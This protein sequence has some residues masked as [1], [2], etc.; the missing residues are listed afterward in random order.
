MYEAEVIYDGIKLIFCLTK[1]CM[2]SQN[3]HVNNKIGQKKNPFWNTD[4]WNN[5]CKVSQKDDLCIVFCC[6]IYR[7]ISYHNIVA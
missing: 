1:N 2:S 5:I 6:M 3:L 7:G 4:K